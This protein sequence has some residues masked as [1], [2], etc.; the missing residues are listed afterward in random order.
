[1]I[2][3]GLGFSSDQKLAAIRL[4]GK[5]PINALSTPKVA[6]VFLACH[7]IEPCYED[8]FQE[9]RSDMPAEHFEL[10]KIRLGMRN[11]AA[12]T[13]A[14]ADAAR[15][16][17]LGIV[18]RATERL[19]TLETEH[20]KVAEKNKARQPDIKA[21]DDSKGGEQ[22]RRLKASSCRLV[23]RIVE[24]IRKGHRNEEQGWGR[25]RQE[26]Q[27]QKQ[28]REGTRHRDQLVVD[29]AGTVRRA[30]PY[31][32]DV[33]SGLA[34]YEA[35]FGRQPCEMTDWPP[36][37]DR[38]DVRGVPDFARWKP[39][40]AAETGERGLGD[41]GLEAGEMR[42]MDADADVPVSLVQKDDTSNI[43]NETAEELVG[44]IEGL[45]GGVG[46][47]LQGIEADA[48]V[49]V[50]LVQTDDASNIQ[51]EIAEEIAS[52]V[53]GLAGGVGGELR[54]VEADADVAV[55]LVQEDDTSNIQNE[56]GER[57]E[58][59]GGLHFPQLRWYHCDGGGVV[60]RVRPREG[61]TRR[62]ECHPERRHLPHE[63]GG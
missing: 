36:E 25:T 24:T 10:Y 51:N 2:T 46:G 43:Q 44:A 63:G 37:I 57:G 60:V 41:E 32:G 31:E 38:N 14:D 49:A 52:E 39:P 18:E 11:F 30:G 45:A 56:I 20:R 22:I 19:R 42:G 12:I 35:E 4:L 5:Q 34:R 3:S 7:A 58:P 23:N 50:L 59:S 33:E 55:L 9:I 53:E 8:P 40:V 62:G 27:R 17:L 29:E 13:P 26:R 48:D 15:A 47:E 61:P 6:Q 1:M 21:H 16:V 28:A 54:A